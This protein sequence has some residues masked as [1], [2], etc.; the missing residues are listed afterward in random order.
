MFFQNFN[1][2]S[3]YQYQK[4]YKNINIISFVSVPIEADTYLSLSPI[5]AGVALI[6]ATIL[7][8]AC[9]FSSSHC[10]KK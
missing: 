9:I 7:A 8:I 6:M 1:Y 4:I 2:I 10:H 3:K 5:V